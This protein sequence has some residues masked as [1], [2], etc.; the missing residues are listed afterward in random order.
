[1][2]PD[3]ADSAKAKSRAERKRK[4]PSAK[5]LGQLPHDEPPNWDDQHPIF[6]LR[7]VNEDHSLK[8][9]TM[10]QEAKAD[11]AVRLQTLASMPWKQIRLEPRHGLGT[12]KLPT[13]KLNITLSAPFDDEE[14]VTVFRYS[15]LLP[16]VGVRRQ[17]TFHILA[18]ERHYGELY[19]HGD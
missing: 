3:R 13:K 16:M 18:V 12:E 8:N 11:F 14:H 7:H 2:T 9:D 17:A 4:R 19:D 1:M 6:C 15:S 10:T 5:S